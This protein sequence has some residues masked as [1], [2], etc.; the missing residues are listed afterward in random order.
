MRKS[1]C[2][3]IQADSGG[4]VKFCTVYQPRH[5]KP[6]YSRRWGNWIKSQLV[7]WQSPEHRKAARARI[8]VRVEGRKPRDS[9][10]PNRADEGPKVRR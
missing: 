2:V 8:K 10:A 1:Y 7:A 9:K 6:G 4:W 3:W 5:M